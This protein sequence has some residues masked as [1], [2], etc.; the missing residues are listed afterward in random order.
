M[1]R[2]KN[3]IDRI[4]TLPDQE[5]KV[6]I[7]ENARF[8]N[9]EDALREW[10]KHNADDLERSRNRA[11]WEAGIDGAPP[12]N[13]GK[14]RWLGQWGRTN[15]NPGSARRAL[16]KEENPYND[17]Q[18]SLD[19]FGNTPT[20]YGTPYQQQLWEPKLAL[21]ITK[22][23]RRWSQW[24]FN[25]QYNV[26]L[27]KRDGV[28][29]PYFTDDRSWQFEVRGLQQMKFPNQCKPCETM[30]PSFGC[31]VEMNVAELFSFIHSE[32][33]AKLSGWNVEYCK[34]VAM[35]AC[36]MA[37]RRD[38]YEKLQQEWKNHDITNG[39][40]VPKI[41][42]VH[43]WWQ[44]PSGKLSHGIVPYGM[45]VEKCDWMFIRRG[46]YK[47]ASRAVVL[48]TDGVG[49]NGTLHSI[50]GHGQRVFD[51]S[52]QTARIFSA[53]IDQAMDSATT[54]IQVANEDAMQS[55]PFRVHGPMKIYEPGASV[56]Q[57]PPPNLSQNL[58]PAMSAMTSLVDSESSGQNITDFFTSQGRTTNQQDANRRAD[59]NQLTSASMALF[60]GSFE[61][62]F[63]EM[64]RRMKRRNYRED[65][66]GGSEVFWLRNE[67]HRLGVPL[68]ALYE[69]DVDR[70]TINTGIGRGSRQARMDALAQL[71]TIKGDMDARAKNLLNREFTIN[72]TGSARAAD[73]YFPVEEGLRP[74]QQA[75]NAIQ[76]N[77]RLASGDQY[78][79]MSVEIL[80]DQDHR[81]H[82]E[83]HMAFLAKL[84]ESI[85]VDEA[86][87]DAMHPIIAP[88]WG[89]TVDQWE[90]MDQ[91]DPLYKV[92]KNQLKQW[93]EWV[94]NVGKQLLAKE[95]DAAQQQ[96]QPG[97]PQQEDGGISSAAI[98]NFY[99][100]AD[101]NAKLAQQ[102]EDLKFNKEMHALKVAGEISK[103]QRDALKFRQDAAQR[104]LTQA[105]PV[106]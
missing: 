104:A 79:I 65:D 59:A 44:E 45:K 68:E 74:G 92:A 90:L 48:F 51:A 30:I 60:F 4:K 12:Y 103:I 71:A 2:K 52:V 95:A 26:H 14:D 72:V 38:D 63:R 42:V 47:N 13:Q 25:W 32:R 54:H 99:R 67:L 80:P 20:N 1:A 27:F 49:T 7:T 102:Q 46:R 83:N 58:L 105:V 66:P 53:F 10:E 96:M 43:F 85:P 100:V 78:Q 98:N 40:G 31:Q 73:E 84:F 89:H 62:L 50:R 19:V 81:V 36:E 3:N 35:A 61:R 91:F 37:D 16:Q 94:A 76:E 28:S 86:G 87:Q 15:F 106:Q 29:I 23:I 56:M 5:G 9:A 39:P 33:V 8:R 24:A 55:V 93:G 70:I 22:A 41:Q 101:A 69:I 77:G 57:I 34:K 6:Y 64:V 88:V 11:M 75:E 18:E 17:L 21:A 82:V 97:D